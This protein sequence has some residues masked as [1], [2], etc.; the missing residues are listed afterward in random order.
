[1]S[2]EN[3]VSALSDAEILA[4]ADT[5]L[6]RDVSQRGG[7][8]MHRIMFAHQEQALVGKGVVR[9][10]LPLLTGRMNSF[11]AG[12]IGITSE[13][14]H[15]YVEVHYGAADETTI[16]IIHNGAVAMTRSVNAPSPP[17]L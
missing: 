17:P 7:L 2:E 1:M 13:T 14:R 5:H 3:I 10:D 6:N 8:M 4:I 12:M 15:E 9:R 11:S 16:V